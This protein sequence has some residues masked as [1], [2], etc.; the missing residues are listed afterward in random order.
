[1]MIKGEVI[2]DGTRLKE[3]GEGFVS[4]ELIART[5]PEEEM[6]RNHSLKNIQFNNEQMLGHYYNEGPPNFSP[7]RRPANMAVF[8]HKPIQL[9]QPPDQMNQLLIY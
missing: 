4:R 2:T 5:P 9:N 6:K 7:S 8:E 3:H 1:M